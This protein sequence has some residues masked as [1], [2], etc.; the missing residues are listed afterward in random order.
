[1]QEKSLSHYT[2]TE[3]GVQIFGSRQYF[4]R[5][6][7]GGHSRDDLKERFFTF[8]GDA[9]LFMG[10]ATDYGKNTWCYQAK[11]G[12]LFS[13][14]ALT[15]GV[16]LAGAGDS[17]SGWFH[18]SSDITATW[19]HGWM[20]YRLTRFSP[21]FP[22]VRVKIE[23]FP[24]IKLDGFL[25]HYSIQ[26]DQRILFCAGFGGISDFTGRFEYQQAP[27]RD[28]CTEDCRDNRLEIGQ[29]QAVIHGPNQTSMRIGTSF[30]ADFLADSA[31]A[32]TEKYP[33][34]FLTPHPGEAQIVKIIRPIEA[35][36]HFRGQIVVLRNGTDADLNQWLSDES[37]TLIKRQIRQKSAGIGFFTPDDALNQ[38]VPDLAVALDAS[39]HGNTFY[40]GAQ[41]YHAPF[42]GWRGWY[43]PSLFGWKE[44]VQTAIFSHFGTI[45][46]SEGPERVWWDGG[47]RPDLDH[48]GTQYHH[49]ENSS[50]FLTALLHRN[51]IYD[52]QE[53]ALDMTLHFLNLYPDLKLA[54]EIFDR[55]AEMLA[56]EERILDPDQDGLYQNFL[57]T[58][59]SD[60]HSYHGAGC[61]QASA[62]N[63]A[64]NRFAAAIA[65]KLGRDGTL[66]EQR[67]Q[68]IRTAL[69]QK[70]WMD[71]DEVLAESLDTLGNRLLHPSPELSTIYLAI[72]CECV[73]PFQGYRMLKF[74]ERKLQSVQTPIRQGR[75]VYS[76]NWLPK[77]YSTCGIFPAENACLALAYFQLGQRAGGLEIM[78][79]LLDAY[80]LSHNPGIIRHVLSASG[81]GDSG[82]LD[83]TDVSSTCF[84]MLAEGLWGIRSQLLEDQISITPQLPEDWTH[85]ELQL[86]DIQLAWRRERFEETLTVNTSVAGKKIIRIPL[87]C[88]E[89]EDLWLNGEAV[90]IQVEPGIGTCF[91]RIERELAAPLEIRVFYGK[92]PLPALKQSKVTA[93]DGNLVAIETTAGRILEIKSPWPEMPAAG[94]K[95]FLRISGKPGFYDVF[96]LVELLQAKV[97]LPM[98]IEL[99][100][101]PE[102]VPLLQFTRQQFIDLTQSFNSSLS[103]LHQQEFRSPRP[104]G[105]SIGMRLNGRYAW[106]WNQC[107]HN[108]VQV[109]E[110]RL[111]QAGGT[112]TVPSGLSFQTPACSNNI[113]C[114]SLWDNFPTRLQIPLQGK[115]AAAAI[116]FICTTNAMQTAVENARLT[117]KYADG[118]HTAVSLVY[119]DN[120]DDW[121]TA[122]L[123]KKNET[124]YF[125]D[126]NHGLVQIIRLD[127]TRELAALEVEA[128]AN[129]VILGIL[130]VT[131]L[132]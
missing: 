50:G 92:T 89:I 119:P 126:F 48:E 82:D 110:A 70:L 68:R 36:E 31:S 7:Y 130:G 32:L 65:R 18:Q 80:Y 49:L 73:D 90:P 85:A 1:M 41:G 81:G 28:F 4:N 116:F 27:G 63:Y 78:N 20:E 55:I 99:E 9:P 5:V 21:Y 79:G 14:L 107:G 12:V 15:P 3:E 30:K 64:A 109:D 123:Q 45:T 44:R 51:D 76:S 22:D 57:N 74:T 111:R 112:F 88:A 8:A 23:V 120:C 47:D 52:M 37:K 105:Y 101:L 94:D 129:E 124:F 121:L 42:L 122:A 54:A 131:L 75:L 106:D 40:H 17:Y 100:A 46:R 95:R 35:G 93:F 103:S 43:A 84:R 2:L 60:G 113:A 108:A 19:Q 77:K 97:W 114:A 53:V 25:V 71:A 10:A 83:F 11:N 34:M 87:R 59:I 96:A 102:V 125:S 58:W 118:A 67:C 66:F 6:L 115:A 128:I 38:L 39:W 91:L 86:P 127:Q 29:Q 56:W 33:S 69:Q 26:T 104:E 72:D 132:Q 117:A 24:L 98:E 16:A 61:A 62:Y 13:G